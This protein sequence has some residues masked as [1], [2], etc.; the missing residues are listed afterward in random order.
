MRP[1]LSPHTVADMASIIH[2]RLTGCGRDWN[3]MST[4]QRAPYVAA[5]WAA[6]TQLLLEF[7]RQKV[8]P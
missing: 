2:S 5:A 7:S 3:H 1:L 4:E 8:T 6:L